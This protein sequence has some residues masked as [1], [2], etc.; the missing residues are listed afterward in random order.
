V[1]VAGTF[2]GFFSYPLYGVDDSNRVQYVGRHGAHGSL[3]PIGSCGAWRSALN[4]GGYRYVVITP[5]RDPWRPKLLS[6]SPEGAWTASDPAARVVY[7]R[8]ALG[9]RITVF[10]LSGRMDPASCS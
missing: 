9:Q 3:T 6:Y 2:G 4:R 8:L 10:E 5:S 7:T 1:A